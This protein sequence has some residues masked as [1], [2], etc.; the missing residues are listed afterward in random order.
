MADDPLLSLSWRNP[1]GDT[2]PMELLG[3]RVAVHHPG[4]GLTHLLN[5]IG[6]AVLEELAQS[7]STLEELLFR[8]E[9]VEEAPRVRPVL[10]AVLRHLDEE[11]LIVPAHWPAP[12]AGL[13]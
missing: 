11:G 7:P 9:L 3:E 4:T 6:L 10:E 8:L 1:W 13:I 12:C 5:P 2:L